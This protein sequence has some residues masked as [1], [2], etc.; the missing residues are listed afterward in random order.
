[1]LAQSLSDVAHINAQSS[2]LPAGF[3][4]MNPGPCF[5]MRAR[6]AHAM[7]KIHRVGRRKRLMCQFGFVCETYANSDD[8]QRY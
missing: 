7:F 1:M 6:H 2:F 3:E 8:T 5:Y 4:Q